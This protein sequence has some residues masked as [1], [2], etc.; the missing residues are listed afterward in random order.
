MTIDYD[1]LD[2]RTRKFMLDEIEHDASSGLLYISP[3]LSDLGAREY[4]SLLVEAV[5][6]Y[7]DAWLAYQLSN[8]DYMNS[9]E[10]RRKKNGGYSFVAVPVS[11]P[12]TLADGEFN[13]FYARGLCLRAIEDGI[14]ELEICRGKAV[15]NPRL[16]SINLIGKRVRPQALLTD[17][18]QSQGV[19]PA[20]GLPPGPNS[21]LTVR[22]PNS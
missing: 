18:R 5:E 14:P 12:N 8:R 6:R 22:I 7:D 16:V 20:L 19:E 4:L 10:R 2:E 13:R 21:G 9:H 15:A 1:H 17:L 11:A 3:R